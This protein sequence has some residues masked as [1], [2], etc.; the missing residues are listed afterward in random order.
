MVNIRSDPN[1]LNTLILPSMTPRLRAMPAVIP[2]TLKR[3]NSTRLNGDDRIC[4]LALRGAAMHRS[5]L[6]S[7]Y[8][9]AKFNI[10]VR[11][12]LLLLVRRYLSSQID[13][14]VDKIITWIISSKRTLCMSYHQ[15]IKE[16]NIA[17]ALKKRGYSHYKA[18]RKRL[19][20]GELL[21]TSCLGFRACKLD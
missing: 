11:T 19:L 4:I 2:S 15:V 21:D 10:R 9:I 8:H 12:R 18:L 6:S 13:S 7:K 14:Q 17:H 1:S 16:L 20:I 5:R 3:T